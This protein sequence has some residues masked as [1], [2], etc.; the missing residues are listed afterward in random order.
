[1]GAQTDFL[2]AEP[3]FLEGWARLFDFGDTLREYNVA[4][5]PKMADGIAMWLDWAVVG[6]DLTQAFSDFS[7]ELEREQQE[8]LAT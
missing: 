2:F 8:S 5:S 3:S 1:M 6:N 4:L 7:E